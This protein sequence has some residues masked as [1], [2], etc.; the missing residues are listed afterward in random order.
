VKSHR[1]S[2][3]V[4]AADVSKPPQLRSASRELHQVRVQFRPEQVSTS[5]RRFSEDDH[6]GARVMPINIFNTFDEPLASIGS[7]LAFGIND[8]DQ[9]VGYYQNG[10]ATTASY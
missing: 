5:D 6:R 2:R 1:R 10:T 3:V 7:T 4:V 9:I 8:A